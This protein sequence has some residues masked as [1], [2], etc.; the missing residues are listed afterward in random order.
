MVEADLIGPCERS[1]GIVEPEHHAGVDVLGRADA[2]AER[3]GA[4][5]DHLAEDALEH[6][7]GRGPDFGIG[8]GRRAGGSGSGAR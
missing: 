4:L 2:F 8:G 7:A 6:A 3:E 1:A 5:V